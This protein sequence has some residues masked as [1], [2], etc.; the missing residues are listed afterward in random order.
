LPCLSPVPVLSDSELRM[1]T[2]V[3]A[4][5]ARFCGTSFDKSAKGYAF[6]RAAL[7]D[8]AFKARLAEVHR[9]LMAR[10]STNMPGKLLTP[11]AP[12]FRD[13]ERDAEAVLSGWKG[14]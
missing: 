8:P 10:R 13:L 7:I 5:M 1:V 6:A 12:L 9:R 2:E 11:I 4:E 3:V 14:E